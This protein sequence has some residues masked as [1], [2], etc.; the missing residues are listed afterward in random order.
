MKK[1]MVQFRPN[2]DVPQNQLP[3]NRPQKFVWENM[4]T[5]IVKSWWNLEFFF[6]PGL[7]LEHLKKL[8]NLEVKSKNSC[9]LILQEPRETGD[10]LGQH[11]SALVFAPG[12]RYIQ[13]ILQLLTDHRLQIPIFLVRFIWGYIFFHSIWWLGTS[14]SSFNFIFSVTKPSHVWFYI[15]SYPL[16]YLQGCMPVYT[17]ML[18][19]PISYFRPYPPLY[20]ITSPLYHLSYQG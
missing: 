15:P 13:M 2:S 16:L 8:G 18:R 20:T 7:I 4:V 3:R 12:Y 17:Q 19:K 10:T 14:Y 1:N 11:V 6:C 9:I 5:D